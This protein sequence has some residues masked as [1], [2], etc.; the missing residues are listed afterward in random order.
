MDV[1]KLSTAFFR[2]LDG[3]LQQ[4]IGTALEIAARDGVVLR[5]NIAFEAARNGRRP[6]RLSKDAWPLAKRF[7]CLGDRHTNTIS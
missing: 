2:D 6:T 3:H 4:Q 7:E 5:G 1:I